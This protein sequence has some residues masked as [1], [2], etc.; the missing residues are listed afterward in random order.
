LR[1]H[2]FNIYLTFDG[3]KMIIFQLI[4]YLTKKSL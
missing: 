2:L 3:E 1:E 4:S